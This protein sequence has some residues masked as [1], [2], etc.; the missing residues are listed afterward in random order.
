VDEERL[1]ASGKLQPIGFGY[2][3]IAKTASSL[4]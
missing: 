1:I 4:R 2:T 3:G